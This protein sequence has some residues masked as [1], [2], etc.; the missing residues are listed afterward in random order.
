MIANGAAAAH[1]WSPKTARNGTWTID[2]SGIQWAFDGI[3]RVGWT[4]MCAADLRE[5]PDEVDVEALPGMEG[6]RDVHVI[7]RIGIGRCRE[8]PDEHRPDGEGEPVQQ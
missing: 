4:G 1:G 3:G 5:D 6:A 7:G 2:A 8:V